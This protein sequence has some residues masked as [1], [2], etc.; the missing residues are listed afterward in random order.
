MASADSQNILGD[1]AS[2]AGMGANAAAG[3]GGIATTTGSN[4][5]NSM[6]NAGAAQA[7]GINAWGVGINNAL[8]GAGA[9]GYMGYQNAMNGGIGGGSVWGSNSM[10]GNGWSPGGYQINMPGG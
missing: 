2:A 4:M 8:T 5:A 10:G 6:Q 1:Y 7:A 3:L 9:Y